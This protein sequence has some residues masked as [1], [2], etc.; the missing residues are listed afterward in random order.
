MS[1]SRVTSHEYI[2]QTYSTDISER[3][4]ES[5]FPS[6]DLKLVA[7]LSKSGMDRIHTYIHT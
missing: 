2:L 5:D 7:L 4:C 3:I 1:I 6:R